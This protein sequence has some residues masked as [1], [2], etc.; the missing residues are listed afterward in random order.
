MSYYDNSIPSIRNKYVNGNYNIIIFDNG[1]KVRYCNDDS[2]SPIFPE[3][4]DLKITNKCPY[5][6]PYCHENSRP[7]GK[8]AKL[9]NDD[10]TFA[11]EFMNTLRAGTELAIG[12]GSVMSHSELE[13]FLVKLFEKGIIANI[14]VNQ[15]ELEEHISFIRSLLDKNLIN[16]IG[17]SYKRPSTML[18]RFTRSYKNTVIHIICGLVN[19]VDIEYI[20]RTFNKILILGYKD[21]RKG[22]SYHNSSVDHNLDILKNKLD[23]LF[24]RMDTTSFDN[25][26]LEQLKIRDVVDKETFDA[27]YMGD[28]GEFTMYIDLPNNKFAKSSIYPEEIRHDI[29]NN[30]DDMF[31]IVRS[32]ANGKFT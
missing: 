28:D 24:W 22:L 32:D 25:L 21:F 17:V 3:S 4:I 30:I 2:F 20:K 6:C 5:S 8:E 10:G 13:P 19:D 16:G 1:S 29:C 11:F 27:I 23:S 26:A 18:E 9:L 7:D 31:K 14:T 12:G 15:D